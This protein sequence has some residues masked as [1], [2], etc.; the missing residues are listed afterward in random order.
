M[1]DLV[2]QRATLPSV[3]IQSGL[4]ARGVC[5][6]RKRWTRLRKAF[7]RRQGSQRRH[8]VGCAISFSRQRWCSVRTKSY[9]YAR[10][11]TDYKD[12]D[13]WC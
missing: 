11:Y 7:A 6:E 3:F 1:L 5:E 9:V 2:G 4:H 10:N 12:D 13:V 8:G